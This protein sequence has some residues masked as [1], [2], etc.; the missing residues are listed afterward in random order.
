MPVSRS[1][2]DANMPTTQTAAAQLRG[3]LNTREVIGQAQGIL[4]E[5]DR[6]SARQAFNILRRASQHLNV[7]LKDVAQELVETGEDPKT[8]PRG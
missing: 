5:R 2:S 6:I 1:C 8:G 4:M 3:A 7:K